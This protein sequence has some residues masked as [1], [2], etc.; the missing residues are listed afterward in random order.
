[1]YSI[2]EK[3]G[4]AN[5]LISTIFA[6]VL[7]FAMGMLRLGTLIRYIPVPIVIGFT[8][9]IAVLIALSQF[10]D[11]FGL[12]IDKMPGDFFA[13]LQTHA[14]NASTVNWTAFGLASISL[15]LIFFW[16]RLT[17]ASIDTG[18]QHHDW[19]ICRALGV[20]PGTIVVLAL[21]TLAVGL[22]DLQ[23]DTI[24][25]RFGGIPRELPAFN[26]PV[27]SWD[28]VKL[29]FPP[30]IT[31]VLLGA[32]ESLLC[33]RIADNSTGDRDDPNQE[34]M[35]QGVANFLTPFFGGMPVTGTIARTLTNIRAGAVSPIAGIV[36]ALTLLAIVLIAAP[37][38]E[39]IPLAA[40]A[41]I[42]MYVAWNMG[43]WHEF[44]RL[45]NFRAS[46]CMVMVAT[47]LLTVI[48]DLTVAVQAGLVLAC[49]FFIY[50]IASLTKIEAISPASLGEPL[51]P[52]VVAYSIYGS[53]FFA[54]VGKMEDLIAPDSLPAKAM[55][56]ELHQLINLDATGLDALENMHKLLRKRGSRLIL[57]S[58]NH[59]P[60]SLMTRSGFI[61][62]LGRENCVDTF[63]AAMARAREVAG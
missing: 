12:S 10:K 20:I 36:H 52:G 48:I 26:L 44:A 22:F 19:R 49:I 31:I 53:L 28:L 18:R 62:R 61:E 35:A 30:T 34:L 57:C 54:A 8:N 1:V 40:L 59:Q 25:S 46:Y 3:Y 14:G 50:R 15:V 16:P 33:V 11:F 55:I 38:A 41:A 4:L 37:L 9:G 23:V 29:L 43:E 17:I 21:S 45:K 5:L 13:Q 7:L 42:L 47:F 6:G 2:V 24:G 60:L 32:I 56:L 27:F 51:P 63:S 58:L 39:D